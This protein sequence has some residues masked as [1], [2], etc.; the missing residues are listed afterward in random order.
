M[1]VSI[2]LCNVYRTHVFMY[3]L[4]FYVLNKNQHYLKKKSHST[5]LPQ[6]IVAVICTGIALVVCESGERPAEKANAQTEEEAD[7][8]CSNS[9]AQGSRVCFVL[10]DNELLALTCKTKCKITEYIC[11]GKC[12][13][14]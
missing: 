1:Y 3:S 12:A 14:S 5:C 7:E 8:Y 13:M 4:R 9:C 11:Y 10:C 6:V 2:K